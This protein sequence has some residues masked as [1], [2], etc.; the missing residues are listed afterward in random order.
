MKIQKQQ[1]NKQKLNK[2]KSKTLQED[3]GRENNNNILY[4]LCQ[5]V[6]QARKK[7]EKKKEREVFKVA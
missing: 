7:N 2:Q 6:W 4:I 3:Q 1:T 5:A